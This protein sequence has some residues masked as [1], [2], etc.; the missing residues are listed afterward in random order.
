MSNLRKYGNPPFKA[1]VIHGGP[2]APGEMAPV[3]RKL[4]EL[5]GILEPLQTVATLEG[6]VR[7][8]KS[9]IEANTKEPII[10]I[11]HSWGAMLSFIVTARFPSLVKK[12]ILIGSGPYDHKYSPSIMQNRLNRLDEKER[13]ELEILIKNLETPSEDNHDVMMARLGALVSKTD[14]YNP[15]PYVSEVLECQSEIFHGVWTEAAEMRRRGGFIKLVQSIS[16]P[17]VAIHGD[18]DP[19]PPEGIKKPLSGVIKD[20]RFILMEKCGH[21]PWVEKEA[22]DMFFDILKKEL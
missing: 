18:Y 7:E 12:L 3:A 20:F 2:G 14:S 17:V 4:S 22:R 19:H 15:M 6:Q 11:G 13:L 9:L 10:L 5:C 1:A 8:L 21:D 16:C